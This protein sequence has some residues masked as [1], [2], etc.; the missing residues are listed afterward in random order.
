M[1]DRLLLAMDQFDSGQTALALAGGLATRSG[2]S[3]VV[4]H[5]RERSP[6]MQVPPLETLAE[7]RSLVDN[8][9][10][11]LVRTG[12]DSHCVLGSAG[13]HLVARAIVEE[14]AAWDCDAIILGSTRLRGFRRIGG[15]GVRERVVRNSPLPVLVAPASLQCQRRLPKRHAIHHQSVDHR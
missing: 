11:T 5:V 6:Y 10:T 9:V 8:A 7:A 15:A 13:Q 2:A 4:L 3:I 14:A 12:I 1:W